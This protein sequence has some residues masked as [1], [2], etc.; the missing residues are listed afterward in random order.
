MIFSLELEIFWV[1]VQSIH[2]NSETFGRNWLVKMAVLAT[3]FCF[4]HGAKVSEAVQKIGTDK[5]SI[6]DA[7]CVL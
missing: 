5:K 3:S 7:P 6:A 4:D 1:A 2:Q